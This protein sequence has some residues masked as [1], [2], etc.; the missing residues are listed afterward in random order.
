MPILRTGD[1]AS[2]GPR[3]AAPGSSDNQLMARLAFG[4]VLFTM[5]FAQATIVPAVNPFTVSPDFVLMLLFAGSMYMGVREGLSWLFVAGI[6][7]DVLAMDPLG[8]NGLA[9]LPAVLLVG[10]ARQPVFRANIL[11]PLG[12]MLV[13]TVAHALILCL[14]RGIMPD[15]TIVLQTLMHAIIF[16]FLYFA[17]RWLE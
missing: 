12:L 6:L 3:L 9:L 5:V 7:T 13:A 2:E 10:P 15:I 14:I 11:I 4:L 16:P 8:S 1:P 17:L